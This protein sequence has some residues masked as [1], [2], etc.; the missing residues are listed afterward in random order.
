MVLRGAQ[1]FRE[2]RHGAARPSKPEDEGNDAQLGLR[3]AV[4]CG[5][6]LLGAARLGGMR[7]ML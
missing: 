6:L 1:P 7:P 3:D 4:E 5:Q 2:D